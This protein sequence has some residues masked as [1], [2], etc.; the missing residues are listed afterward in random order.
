M[1]NL[2]EIFYNLGVHDAQVLRS[3]AASLEGTVIIN[4]EA[5]IPDFVATK[6]YSE[7]PVGAPVRDEDQVWTLL[8]PHNAAH[9][10]GCPSTLRALWGLCHTKNPAKAKAWV[11]P[12]GTSGVYMKDE[13]YK[14]E[15]GNVWRSLVDNNVY[16]AAA[17]AAN[18]EIVIL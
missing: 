2:T 12:Y 4:R 6:D 18:W 13:C 11:D 8:Q 16:T 7:W 3:E 17:Y 9:Y 5:S 14:D 1:S 10:D 15:D